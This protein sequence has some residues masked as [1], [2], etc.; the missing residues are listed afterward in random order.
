[1]FAFSVPFRLLIKTTDRLGVDATGFLLAREHDAIAT[2]RRICDQ[3]EMIP[4]AD[5]SLAFAPTVCGFTTRNYHDN[6]GVFSC[7]AS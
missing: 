3:R 2:T 6:D 5:P 4:N 1:M 7:D